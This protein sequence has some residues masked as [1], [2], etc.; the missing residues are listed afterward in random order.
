MLFLEKSADDRQRRALEQIWAGKLG[1]TPQRQFPWAWKSSD[2][3]GVEQ[4]EIE[5][6][7]T[8]GRGWFKAGGVVVVRISGP[9]EKQAA[10]SCVIP[11]HDRSGRELVAER[12]TVEEQQPLSFHLTDRCGYEATFEYSSD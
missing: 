1:G 4:V 6:D 9:F 2:L 11:G 10:V 8:P 3:V 7:H 12:I 5:I